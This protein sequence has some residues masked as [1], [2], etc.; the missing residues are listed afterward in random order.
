MKLPVCVLTALMG[1][2]RAANFNIDFNSG[3]VQNL[4]SA[5]HG[6]DDSIP[7]EILQHGCYCSQMQTIDIQLGSNFG[8][9]VDPIDIL[10]REWIKA[11]RCT[12][13]TGACDEHTLL[14]HTYDRDDIY[15]GDNVCV[16][17]DGCHGQVC[18]LDRYYSRRIKIAADSHG[19]TTH[20]PVEPQHCTPAQTAHADLGN[21]AAPNSNA[22]TCA[23]YHASFVPSSCFDKPGCY[24]CDHN[25]HTYCIS[26]HY[27]YDLTSDG[28]CELNGD[29]IAYVEGQITDYV[30]RFLCTYFECED[31]DDVN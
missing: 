5:Y 6:F 11:R 18:L 27:G 29:P 3:V 10:C 2:T 25:D 15:V 22:V 7:A 28:E 16:Q 19:W 20:H 21:L 31:L 1:Y 14:L 23:D 9:P 4:V 8:T 30:E 12:H 24:S 17:E 26:C 13:F